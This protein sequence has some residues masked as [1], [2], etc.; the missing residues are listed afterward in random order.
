MTLMAKQKCADGQHLMSGSH[1]LRC[2]EFVAGLAKTCKH[3]HII[4]LPVGLSCALCPPEA[5]VK[6]AAAGIQRLF[7][8]RDTDHPMPSFDEIAR[9]ALEAAIPSISFR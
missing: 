9:A 7:I 4:D 3:G 2:H 8:E 5:T 1:C 6:K